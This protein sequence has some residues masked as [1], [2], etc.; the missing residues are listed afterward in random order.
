MGDAR[1]APISDLSICLSLV[2]SPYYLRFTLTYGI[3]ALVLK[4]TNGVVA[5]PE[6]NL[7]RRLNFYVSDLGG[8]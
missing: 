8:L 5:V 1:L 4:G 6:F 3:L 2:T 7:R